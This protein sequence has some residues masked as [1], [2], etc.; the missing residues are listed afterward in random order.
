M[1]AKQFELFLQ[2]QQQLLA[3]MLQPKDEPNVYLSNFEAF[4][5]TKE[6]FRTYKER[7][8]NFV[9]LKGIKKNKPACT[10]L[11]LNSI[12]ATHYDL[13]ASLTAP[14]NPGNI[15][16]ENLIKII[17]EHLAPKRNV[18]VAQHHF[19][20]TFQSDQQSISDFNAALK[21]N[22]GDCAFVCPGCA[23]SISEVFLR[24]QFIRGLKDNNIRQH[25]LQSSKNTYSEV[26]S[27]A[28][29]SESAKA[30][31]LT[32]SCRSS[33][34]PTGMSIDINKVKESNYRSRSNSSQRSKQQSVD[35]RALGID[36]LCLRCGKDNH[37]SKDCR[38]N[39]RN[40]KCSSC[41]KTGHL[42]RVCISTL[43]SQNRK[44]K[45]AN[46]ITPY[47]ETSESNSHVFGINQIVNIYKNYSNN[48]DRFFASVN[49]EGADIQFEV[50]SGSGFTFLPRKEYNRLRNKPPIEP[51]NIRFRS[52]TQDVFVPDGK[53]NVNA[54][55]EGKFIKDDVYIVPDNFAALLGRT[56][57]RRLK[58]NLCHTDPMQG[59]CQFTNIITTDEVSNLKIKFP[60]IFEERIGCVPNIQ[61]KLNLRENAT[62]VFFRER[63]IPYALRE[64]VDKE[65][66]SLVAM[67]IISA[68]A[69][70]DWGSPLVVIPK[71]DGTVRLCVDYKIGVNQR[72]MDAHYPIK[73]IEHIF[74]NLRGSKFFCQ[75]D[76]YKAYLHIP[77]DQQSSSIQTISTHRGT[78]NMN[79]LSFGIK[80]APA[81]FNRI[82]DQILRDSPK[83]EFYFDD[84]VVHGST[85][86]ECTENLYQCLKILQDND[87]HLNARKCSFFKEKIE[88]LGHVIEFNNISK[89]PLRLKAIMEL[90]RP[91]STEELQRFLG[92]SN[93]Y[94]KFIPNSSSI[95]SP[96]RELLKKGKRFFWSAGC[97]A[98]FIKLKQELSSNRVLVPYDPNLPIQLACDASPTGIAG[99]LSHVIGDSERP[100]AYAS[101][102]LTD[103]ERN[104]SQLDR[105]ALAI[106]FSVDHFFQYLFGRKFSLL[107]DNQPLI[108]IFHQHA[109][110][111]RMTAARLQRYAA[112][113]SGFDYKIVF[114]KGVENINVDCLS[115]AP[116]NLQLTGTDSEI[117]NEVNHILSTNLYQISS[118]NIDAKVI[119]EASLKDQ[120]L[121]K[122]LQELR[123][124]SIKNTEF[125]I[126]N[127]IIFKGERVVVPMSLRHI[128]LQ[129]L[130]HTHIGVTKMKQL[131]RR[132]V[133]WLNIDKDIEHFV[134]AC[135]DCVSGRPSPPKAPLHPWAE[136]E[137]NWDRLHIDYAGPFQGHHFLVIVDAKSKWVEVS[138]STSSPTSTSTIS[139]LYDVFARYGFPDVIVSD[140][141]T[142]FTSEEFRTFCK[143]IGSFQKFIAPGHP[144][145]N[146]LAERTIQTIKRR[147]SAM[148]GSPLPIKEKLREIL[149]RYRATP[150]ADN[151]SPAEK[152]LKR[153]IRISLDALRPTQHTRNSAPIKVARQLRV[154]D[155]VLARY[156]QPNK[157][158]WQLGTILEKFGQLHY[159]VKLDN[160][161]QIKRHINQLRLSEIPPKVSFSIPHQDEPVLEEVLPS[162]SLM[163]PVQRSPAHMDATPD[164]QEIDQPTST[165]PAVEPLRRSQRNRRPPRYLIDYSVGEL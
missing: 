102:S 22:I 34:Q 30:D 12:G 35:F 43:L 131:A 91:K 108:R 21:R 64:R 136:P 124:S 121:S 28:L 158:L 58:I 7:F 84:I 149:F 61:V 98:A 87:L 143:Q 16:F 76:L 153:K 96:L 163:Q 107:T 24:A 33:T 71:S 25:L 79:R 72:L 94:A 118:I 2:M 110:L 130:H 50:D 69:I 104:Y 103:A 85:K 135:K 1:D 142:I 31:A 109:Q 36:N 137:E 14:E 119:Q 8:L 83:T 67:G 62:P 147:L 27:S 111:P 129:E 156:Y 161:N 38:T 133:Y 120:T 68:V 9:E 37:L 144:A 139:S 82:M 101:R 46:Q 42:S 18:L 114:R 145:T 164:D 53:I 116:V 151:Q 105:E 32:L 23:G 165:P 39:T 47:Q 56:W 73:K 160:G 146:G 74:N 157:Q 127:D 93:F 154:G 10:R 112:F 40:L 150:L 122:L 92:M 95:T 60:T 45:Y 86:E 48:T 126:N 63:E 141:A 80:T 132:Y 77:V 54:S 70:S 97:E 17:E 115:R 106:I 55:F 26:L 15:G 89:S 19:L 11:L 65:L 5:S 117:N 66:D 13:I 155:R 88:F 51:V 49:V 4:D 148:T 78:Y 20:S 162:N 29:V 44:Q 59:K 113:L 125:T 75:L 57:I 81:E 3:S 41:K 159:Q 152:F 128:V 140:N 123:T 90:P 6:N 99:V 100:I 138:A 134:A 52:Y